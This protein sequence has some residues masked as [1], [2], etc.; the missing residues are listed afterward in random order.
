MSRRSRILRSIVTIS[1][2]MPR[3]VLLL[4]AL[5]ILT[6]HAT[7][8]ARVVFAPS[9]PPAA[10]TRVVPC[11]YYLSHAAMVSANVVHIPA[12]PSFCV[13]TGR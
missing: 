9:A 11:L 1:E 12:A 5:V 7:A 6:M 2:T 4:A 13:I 3:I 8:P 10:A